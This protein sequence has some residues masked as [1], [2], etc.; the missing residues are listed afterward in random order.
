MIIEAPSQ[1]PQYALLQQIG[2]L[3]LCKGG[4]CAKHG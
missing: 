4:G 1:V 2:R 3:R